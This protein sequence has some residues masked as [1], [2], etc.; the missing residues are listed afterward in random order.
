MEDSKIVLVTCPRC[1]GYAFKA[2]ASGITTA[3]DCSPLGDLGAV[4]RALTAGRNIYEIIVGQK[5]RSLGGPGTKWEPNG[6]TLVASHACGAPPQSMVAVEVPE[7]GPQRAP[8]TPGGASAGSRPQAA[9]ESGSQ[10]HTEPRR[11]AGYWGHPPRAATPASRP[12]SEPPTPRRL[13]CCVCKKLIKQDVEEFAAIEHY[14]TTWA[15]HYECKVDG[16]GEKL[17]EIGWDV[18]LDLHAKDLVTRGMD[19]VELPE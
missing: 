6:R 5:L 11:T 18:T 12:R 8:V 14:R 13:T 19:T 1:S 3:V 10:G 15:Q 16:F 17:R 2:Q 4:M 9:R 7:Q